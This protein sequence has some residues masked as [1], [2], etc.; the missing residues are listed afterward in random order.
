MS[1]VVLTS[2]VSAKGKPSPSPVPVTSTVHDFEGASALQLQS[3]GMGP[4]ANDSGVLNEISGTNG[5]WEI[6]LQSQTARTVRLTFERVDGNTSD[7]PDG[8]Y[9]AR[10]ISRCFDSVG[11]IT[12][13]LTIAEG[14]SN[15][16]C[17]LRVGFT[18]S[19]KQY[20]LVMSPLYQATGWATVSCSESP[21]TDI[22][23][24]CDHWSITP[25][26]G[27]N[28]TVASLYEVGKGGREI[29]RGYYYNTYRIDVTR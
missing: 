15:D 12:G 17:S 11:N 19:G 13:F 14:T 6:D 26:T 27:D 28:A 1:L 22:D 20:F 25:G 9:N 21:G 2:G 18:A 4:Y 10:L 29:F 3:D 23:T 7:V 16:R 8:E 24:D 5:D